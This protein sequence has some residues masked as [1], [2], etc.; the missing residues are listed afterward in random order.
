M[1]GTPDTPAILVTQPPIGVPLEVKYSGGTVGMAIWTGK[2]WRP[3][4]IAM[5]PI[6][7]RRLPSVA[8]VCSWTTWPASPVA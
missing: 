2:A 5:A 4:Y 3:H 1:T 6:A 8:G 7:W